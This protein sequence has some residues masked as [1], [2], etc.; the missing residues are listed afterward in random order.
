MQVVVQVLLK[1]ITQLYVLLVAVDKVIEI[2]V[3]ITKML[4]LILAVAVVEVTSLIM[5]AADQV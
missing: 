3:I 2:H 4:T 1:I 5:V